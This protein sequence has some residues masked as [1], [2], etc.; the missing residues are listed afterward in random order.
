MDEKPPSTYCNATRPAPLHDTSIRAKGHKV[1]SLAEA[2]GAPVNQQM[3]RDAD[4]PADF[5]TAQDLSGCWGCVCCPV[6]AACERKR[7]DGR[8]ILWHQGICL[9]CFCP[10]NEAWDREGMSNQ[11]RKRGSDETLDYDPQNPSFVCFGL[12]CGW[13]WCP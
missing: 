8:D 12:G 4:L 9:P 3:S 1:I 13:R 6:F 5:L 10:Y 2:N 11:F 7:A